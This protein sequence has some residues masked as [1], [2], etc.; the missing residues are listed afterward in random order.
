[1]QTVAASVSLGGRE[2]EG[3]S[4]HRGGK[5]YIAEPVNIAGQRI[6]VSAT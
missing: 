4:V 1:M 2:V 5:K 6:V 3:Q